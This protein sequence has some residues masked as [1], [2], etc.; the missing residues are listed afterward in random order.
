MKRKYLRLTDD[1]KKRVGMG[2][3]MEVE[4]RVCTYSSRNVP[5]LRWDLVS[6]VTYS[7]IP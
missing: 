6:I 3:R 1:W 7:A 4:V 2:A 5:L